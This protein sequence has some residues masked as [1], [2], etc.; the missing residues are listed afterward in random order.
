MRYNVS[1]LDKFDLQ[2]DRAYLT[3]IEALVRLPLLQHQKD[4]QAG[5]NTAGYVSGYRGSPVGTLDMSMNQASKQLAEHNIKFNP[6]VNEDLA[7]T[8]VW[9]TQQI[10]V[11]PDPA[12]RRRFLHVVRQRPRCRSQHGCDQACEQLWD[13]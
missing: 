8:A 4:L 9:G 12:I 10:D 7:A 3:G 13:G 1:L 2:K 6:G 11:L 5:L